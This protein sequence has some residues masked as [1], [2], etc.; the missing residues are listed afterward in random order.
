LI[1]SQEITLKRWT[2]KKADLIALGYDWLPVLPAGAI[3][4]DEVIAAAALTA[5]K[6]VNQYDPYRVEQL[7]GDVSRLLDRIFS[8]R[9]EGYDLDISA[10]TWALDYQ[11]FRDQLN[12]QIALEQVA[13]VGEQQEI[14]RDA[15]QKA[16]A[17]F[18]QA[19]DPL[20]PG[21]KEAAIGK[22]GSSDAVV[23]GETDRRARIQAK[24][25]RLSL[26]QDDLQARHTMPGGSLN[27]GDRLTRLEKLL[28]ED[29]IECYQKAAA[30]NLGL[31][32]VYGINEPLPAPND[33]DF[34]D[35][36]LSW[37]RNVL[38]EL[39]I[40]QQDDVDFDHIIPLTGPASDGTRLISQPAYSGAIQIGGAGTL[41]VDLTNYFDALYGRLWVRGV[42]LSLGLA[43]QG[44]PYQRLY[45][46]SGQVFP[47]P[48]P[49]LSD[50]KKF[51]ARP[52]AILSGIFLDDPS[53]EVKP[54][55]GPNINNLDP[56]GVWTIII[57]QNFGAADNVGHP[58]DPKILTD[59]KLHLL[60]TGRPNKVP[61]SWHQLKF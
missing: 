6:A 51:S 13:Y 33:V 58:R 52:P 36:L 31:S 4:L 24:W 27:F 61:T 26:H 25:D 11:L 55:K 2:E 39:E 40:D 53:A 22:S 47:P 43:D 50:P 17:A 12:D 19:N 10:T 59:I 54:Y 28:S 37:T 21:F 48:T 5:G 18:A 57:N 49:D 34:L 32:A 14:E 60:L 44:D 7:L 23:T 15:Q 20:A 29:V 30:A 56:R 41:N 16:A 9:K 8:Y 35:Y 1:V 3:T 42:A 46:V 45:R 38:R